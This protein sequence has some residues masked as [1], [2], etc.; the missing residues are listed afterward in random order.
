MDLLDNPVRRYAWGSTSVIPALLGQDADG[1]PQA[2]LWVGAHPDD[3]SRLVAPGGSTR[4]GPPAAHPTP[5]RTL[6]DRIAA[7]PSGTLGAQVVAAFGP[8][9]PF[10][11]KVLAVEHPLSLQVHPSKP[12]AQTGFA[13]EEAAGIAADAPERNYRDDN[14]KPEMICALTAFDVLCGFRPVA[15]TLRLL[16]ALELPS[17]QADADQLRSGDHGLRDVVG[18]WLSLERAEA[19]LLVAEVGDAA[20]SIDD[21]EFSLEAETVAALA[22]ANPGDGGV[23]VALLL[24]RVRLAPGEALYLPAGCPHAYLHGTGVEIMASSDNVLRGGL[25]EKHVDVDELLRILD[26]TPGVVH[27]LRQVPSSAGA[28]FEV[29]VPDF[30]LSMLHLDEGPYYLPSGVPQILLTLEGCAILTQPGSEIDLPRGGAAFVGAHEP[31]PHVSG[32]GLVALATTG[33]PVTG[34]AGDGAA[35]DGAR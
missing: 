15:A 20:A 11:L 17:L 10:L 2:E 22:A 25:T 4:A 27:V 12:Q 29:A 3:P 13:T 31:G 16:N 1:T 6:L 9:L 32:S 21:G 5:T 30:A 14:H 33:R 18:R 8:R 28:V 23:L 26:T 7:D 19:A 24:H 35:G 34:A